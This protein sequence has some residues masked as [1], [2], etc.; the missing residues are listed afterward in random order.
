MDAIH[1]VSA[2][3]GGMRTVGDMVMR[4]QLNHKMRLN[5]AKSYIA[6]KLNVSLDQLCDVVEMTEIRETLGLGVPYCEPHTKMTAG[7]EAK[8]NI[9]EK[10]G[11]TINSVERFKKLASINSENASFESSIIFKN[12]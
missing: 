2:G 1:A 8:F 6:K 7:M 5:E 11:I 4:M 10:L 9:A 3:M 12:T